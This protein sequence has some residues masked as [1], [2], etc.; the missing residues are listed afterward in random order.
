MTKYCSTKAAIKYYPLRHTQ[1]QPAHFRMYS[2]IIR[3]CGTPGDAW[4]VYCRGKDV[5]VQVSEPR[6]WAGTHFAP[7]N[8]CPCLSAGISTKVI[9]LMSGV[10][11]PPFL[12]TA[13][14]ALH[15]FILKGRANGARLDVMILQL[16]EFLR[17]S[18]YYKSYICLCISKDSEQEGR[19]RCLANSKTSKWSPH[20][21]TNCFQACSKPVPGLV[22]DKSK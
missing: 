12:S 15:A 4:C 9:K 19:V 21:L 20:A 2:W 10:K 1:S 11:L 6:S 7:G 8:S 17:N 5:V 16:P 18:T 13:R 22:L 14:L 3:E